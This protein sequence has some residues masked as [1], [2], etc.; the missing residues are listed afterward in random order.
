MGV[1][2]GTSGELVYQEN[3]GENWASFGEDINGELYVCA[4]NG[5]VYKIEPE[6]VLNVNQFSLNQQLSPNPANNH[7][8]LKSDYLT[9]YMIFDLSGKL[10]EKKTTQDNKVT[11]DTQSW[12]SGLYLIKTTHEQGLHKIGKILIQH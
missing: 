6:V 9:G 1:L 2:E 10:I 12:P 11:I 4:F 5:V 8:V 7:V 3:F